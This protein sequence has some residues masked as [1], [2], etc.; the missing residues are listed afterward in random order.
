MDETKGIITEIL[1]CAV[2]SSKQEMSRSNIL[3]AKSDYLMKYISAAFVIVNAICAFAISREFIPAAIVCVYY[4]LTGLLLLI[5]MVITIQVQTLLKVEYFP[6]GT[7]ILEGMAEKWESDK[8]VYSILNLQIDNIKYY[9]Q[10]TESLK[11]ANDDRA[12]K[13]KQAYKCF[14]YATVGMAIG[15]LVFLILIA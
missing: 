2:E 5:S 13:L 11:E 15:F 9:S 10:Y 3:L 12:K 8:E 1:S 4:L 7:Q 14:M 6:T